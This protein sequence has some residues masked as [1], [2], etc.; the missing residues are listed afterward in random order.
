[1]EDAEFGQSDGSG[2]GLSK[3]DLPPHGHRGVCSCTKF[4]EREKRGA[5]GKSKLGMVE[6]K[7]LGI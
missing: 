2:R 5:E 3:G 1:M 6:I 4:F 7:A